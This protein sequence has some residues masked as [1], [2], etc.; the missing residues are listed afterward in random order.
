MAMHRK[1]G[2][3]FIRALDE[4]ERTLIE[5][6]AHDALF[7]RMQQDAKIYAFVR[8]A[9]I[10]NAFLIERFEEHSD[11]KECSKDIMHIITYLEDQSLL[12][13]VHAIC[14]RNFL[15][16]VGILEFDRS[17]APDEKL[18]TLYEIVERSIA[19]YYYQQIRDIAHALLES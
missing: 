15:D 16:V 19:V 3:D 14:A 4:F 18:R 7:Q 6:D 5:D 12:E 13:P 1:I 9:G 10:L 2:N 11:S 8:C 17:L